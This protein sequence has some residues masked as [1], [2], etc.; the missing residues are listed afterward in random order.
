MSDFY[1]EGES[2]GNV[3][4]A[5]MPPITNLMVT[6]NG[7]GSVSLSWSALDNATAYGV[8]VGTAAAQ[9]NFGAAAAMVTADTATITGLTPSAA[10][11]F[12][13]CGFNGVSYGSPSNEVTTTA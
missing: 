12:Q 1:P 7:G 9:E 13:V 2:F 5:R 8:F 10:Y 11:W 3:V 6:A 4:P